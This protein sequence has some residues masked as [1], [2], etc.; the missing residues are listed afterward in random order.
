MA[1]RPRRSTAEQRLSEAWKAIWQ[2]PHGR[3]AI[4][5]LL[6]SN[7][8]YSEIVASDPVM[9]AI[10]VGERNVAA[11]IARHIGLKAESYV[12]DAQAATDLVGRFID[13]SETTY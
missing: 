4:S 6:V 12:D 13:A 11:R 9:M 8:V 2:S 1:S 5:E 10:A 7:N 3:V